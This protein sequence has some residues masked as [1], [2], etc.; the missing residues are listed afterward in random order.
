MRTDVSGVFSRVMLNVLCSALVRIT[1][2]ALLA[3]APEEKAS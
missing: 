2:L 1:C 3:A